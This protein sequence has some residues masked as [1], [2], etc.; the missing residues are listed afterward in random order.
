MRLRDVIEKSKFGSRLDV[1]IERGKETWLRELGKNDYRHSESVERILDKL[2]PDD[3]KVDSNIFDHAEIFVLLA[4]VYLHDIG[5]QHN[6]GHH[7][8]KSYDM[9]TDN[10][11]EYTLIHRY[12][13]DAIAIVCRAHAMEDIV[14]IANVDTSFGIGNYGNTNRPLDLR[15]LGSLLRLAD[16]LDN[17]FNRVQGL[18]NQKE[19]IR[20]LIRDVVPYPSKGTI[21]FQVGKLNWSEYRQIKKCIKYSNSRLNEVREF[22]EEI[23]LSYY[24]IWVDPKGKLPM[25]VL[26]D[27]EPVVDYAI[28]VGSI[29]ETRIKHIEFYK[30]ICNCQL[31][32]V[33][34]EKSLLGAT[35]KT[36]VIVL[37]SITLDEA[38]EYKAVLEDLIE[39]EYLQ[40]G[41][42]ILM[43]GYDNDLKKIFN[44]SNITILTHFELVNQFIDYSRYIELFI[45]EYET[46]LI[47]TNELY[48]DLEGKTING[49]KRGSLE[50][51]VSEWLL[52]ENKVQLTLLGEF[53][54]GKSTFCNNLI[55]KLLKNMREDC[56]SRIP[57]LINLKRL[58]YDTDIAATLTDYLVNEMQILVDYNT[59]SKLNEEGNFIL[60]LDGFDEMANSNDEE[61][62]LKAFKQ[63]DRLTNLN[64]KIILT[65]RSH[66][67]R[68]IDDLRGLFGKSRLNEI[69]DD[70]FGYE[71]VDISPYSFEQVKEYMRKWDNDKFDEN[72]AIIESIYN[73][74]DLS[75][76]PVLLAI[77]AKSLPQII[78]SESFQITAA[79]LY[80]VY[81]NFWLKRDDWRSVFTPDERLILSI[82]ISKYFFHND[83]HSINYKVLENTLEDSLKNSGFQTLKRVHYEIR[84]CN[85]LKNDYEGNYSFV[86]KSFMEFLLA[87]SVIE[88]IK[89]YSHKFE[90]DLYLPMENNS[91]RKSITLESESFFVD[92]FIP[93][94]YK[95]GAK[96]FL[97]KYKKSYRIMLICLNIIIREQL[98]DQEIIMSYILV[99]E[100]LSFDKELVINMIMQSS[101]TN[102]LLNTVYNLLK[103][104]NTV[105]E[106]SE[107]YR[108]LSPFHDEYKPIQ[109]I[110]E[111]LAGDENECI[112]ESDFFR[113]P[114]S[115]TLK[116]EFVEWLKHNHNF[117]QDIEMKYFNRKWYR[118][119]DEH[120]QQKNKMKK[121]RSFEELYY[122]VYKKSTT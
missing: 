102:R 45:K 104:N 79:S 60:I 114:Y 71:I 7:E 59:F 43:N 31:S 14:P 44:D 99:D 109:K 98:Y 73:L 28:S 58:K 22:I 94:L 96:A 75:T 97:K 21:E 50:N 119:K 4:A 80:T 107:I 86:H 115:K 2:I 51:I 37:K 16:E 95:C 20:N 3:I 90:C 105:L 110:Y 68:N 120:E 72:M 113:T 82:F 93:Y 41:T 89:S 17:Q 34:S 18:S 63:L 55:Y 62:V 25:I 66:Y 106:I 67:F 122:D 12:E 87:K 69:V 116:K 9:I 81:I 27:D 13:A 6:N 88:N 121:I 10:F 39:K 108:L 15:K 1:L 77:I 101:D 64:S 91:R 46:S 53:G 54:A 111:L 118:A 57:L 85:F 11:L 38:K 103:K 29:L 23:G 48:I 26:D 74:K 42:I 40:H 36:G 33:A 84:T 8:I 5:R 47:Y 30:T 65:C 92:M 49:R 35:N 83:I 61:V 76:R 32:L 100:Q 56:Y 112:V 19:S 70:K 117:N 52:D 24:Q 78:Q